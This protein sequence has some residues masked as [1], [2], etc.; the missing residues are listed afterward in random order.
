MN[1]ATANKYSIFADS[2]GQYEKADRL[3]ILIRAAQLQAPNQKP[4]DQRM[5]DLEQQMQMVMADLD[6]M[7][8]EMDKPAQTQIAQPEPSL[9]NVPAQPVEEQT[10]FNL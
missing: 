5:R 9:P 7:H 10:S 1:I 8:K 3:D 4:L 6:K 2:I